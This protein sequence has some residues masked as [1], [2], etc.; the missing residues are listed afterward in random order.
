MGIAMEEK[1]E[2]CKYLIA[3]LLFDPTDVAGAGFEK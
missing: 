3:A 1:K 2:P